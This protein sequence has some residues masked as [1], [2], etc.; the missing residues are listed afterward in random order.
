MGRLLAQKSGRYFLDADALIESAQGRAIASIFNEEGE[1]YFR[2]LER[3]SARWM[4]ECVR[5]SI[6]S[7]GGGMPLVVE[8][9][10][11]IGVVVY[12]KLPFEKILERISP[13]ERAKRPLFH[14][15]AEAKRLFERREKIY[16]AQAQITVDADRPAG[17]IV[18]KIMSSDG[19]LRQGHHASKV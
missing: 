11:D 9:L 6:I 17:E 5:G 16:E 8:R 15:L 4:A 18:E 12:L 1:A 3:E 13:E 10:H 2:E 19:T 7:T 14:D